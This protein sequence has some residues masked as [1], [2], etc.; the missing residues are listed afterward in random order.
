VEGVSWAPPAVS[1]VIPAL[2]EAENLPFVLPRIPKTVFEV[3]L[4]DGRSTDD[5]IEVAKA[6][7]PDI[8]IV[9]QLGRGKGAA[10]RTGFAAAKG[11]VI[12]MLDADGSTDPAE[13]PSF[14]A[15][16]QGGADFAKGS[17]FLAGG[18][19]LDMPLYRKLGNDGFVLLVR[20]LFRRRFSDLCYGYNA[21]WARV[22]PLLNLDGDGFEI[23]T[24][25]NVRAVRAGLQVVE[26][27]SFEGRRVYG[28]SRLRTIPDGTRV[29]RTIFRERMSRPGAPVR[30]VIIDETTVTVGIRVQPRD[31]VAIPISAQADRLDAVAHPV[32]IVEQ[33][34][35]LEAVRSE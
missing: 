22:L 24:M 27:P 8:R 5:T 17:R 31:P 4:V 34:L 3:I 13:I 9:T 19:T 15:A 10:L 23:E 2:N 6:L 25:M 26:V 35:E 21:F 11:D 16:L 7:W 12:V 20:I 30:P 28:R 18:G 29:L 32:A 33:A 14:V 1:V